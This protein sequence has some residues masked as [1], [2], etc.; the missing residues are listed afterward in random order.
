MW[1]K[2]QS[3]DRAQNLMFGEPIR[4]LHS[5]LRNY[6]AMKRKKKVRM[7]FAHSHKNCVWDLKS[8]RDQ[9]WNNS[10]IDIVNDILDL[11]M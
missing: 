4:R 9:S 2:I 6:I 8:Q 11:R 10:F 3:S 7:T 1:R 5:L